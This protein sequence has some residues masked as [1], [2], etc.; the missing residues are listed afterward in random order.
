MGTCKELTPLQLH[1]CCTALTS[2]QS[3][4][5]SVRL[6]GVTPCS[7][8]PAVGEQNQIKALVR[9]TFDQT[10]KSTT[11]KGKVQALPGLPVLSKQNRI[12]KIKQSHMGL[13]P[14]SQLFCWGFLS[15]AIF[16][17]YPPYFLP[18]FAHFLD[19]YFTGGRQWCLRPCEF[20][21][22]HNQNN[23]LSIRSHRSREDVA[24]AALQ[25]RGTSGKPLF[26]LSS[27]ELFSDFFPKNPYNS[28]EHSEPPY[29]QQKRQK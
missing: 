19:F 15:F 29:F 8:I 6:P 16:S 5:A 22:F 25:I 21:Y 1:V 20:G 24:V 7:P 17:S 18:L 10:K 28:K 3:S 13:K 26:E 14:Q 11:P 4:N 12:N 27:R 9:R 2:W 23:Q